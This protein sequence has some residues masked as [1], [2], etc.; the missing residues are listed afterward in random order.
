MP[1]PAKNLVS[2]FVTTYHVILSDHRERRISCFRLDLPLLPEIP[3]RSAPRNDMRVGSYLI[4]KV[5]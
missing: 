2:D 4:S 1:Q 3:R 5:G